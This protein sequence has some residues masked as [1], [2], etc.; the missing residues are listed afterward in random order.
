MRFLCPECQSPIE[1]AEEVAL[2]E[3]VCPTCGSA[4]ALRGHATLA[5]TV[6]EEPRPKPIVE[7]GQAI[8][9]YKVVRRLG[10]GGL[11]VVYEAQ[12][13][14]LGRSVALKFLH[15]RFSHDRQALDR[16]KREARTASALN[17]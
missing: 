17:H 9:H 11:G 6:P 1:A 16:F 4:F 7:I 5:Y 15:E 3:V 14:R 2:E 13:T 10:G 12:D 8:S